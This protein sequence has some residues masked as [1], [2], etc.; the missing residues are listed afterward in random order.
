MPPETSEIALHP[1]EHA[2][3]VPVPRISFSRNSRFDELA[4]I[5]HESPAVTLRQHWLNEREEGFRP[6][7]VKVCWR[8]RSLSVFAE[9]EDDDIFNEAQKLNDRT[10]LL[11]D[12]FEVFLKSPQEEHYVEIHVTPN[13]QRLQLRIPR[14]GDVHAA[15]VINDPA[16]VF[17][18]A[19]IPQG[20]GRWFVYLEIP[21][22]LVTGSSTAGRTFDLQF[23]F[24]RYD[25]THGKETPVL[26]SSSPHPYASFHLVDNW[27]I[28]RVEGLKQRRRTRANEMLAVA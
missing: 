8:A 3:V 13:N 5:F 2:A 24:S 26:S 11:G 16:A 7:I 25:Y 27:G 23:S 10:F 22:H 21:A 12:V 14:Q 9:M 1:A 18:R 19:W 4:R 6:A 17:S 15:Q 20:G 28:L